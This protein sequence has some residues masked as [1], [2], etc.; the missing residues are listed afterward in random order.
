M[1]TK[2]PEALVIAVS[3]VSSAQRAVVCDHSDKPK[4]APGHFNTSLHKSTDYM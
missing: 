2:L 1:H 4:E 3:S